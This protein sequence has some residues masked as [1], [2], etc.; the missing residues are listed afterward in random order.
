MKVL[1]AAVVVALLAGPAYGQEGHVQRYGEEAKPETQVQINANKAAE[2]A[3]RDSLSNIPDAGPV[4]PWGNARG[5]GAPKEAAKTAAKPVAKTA[6]K[7]TAPAKPK[8]ATT[9]GTTTN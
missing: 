4:D 2:K 9:A 1:R 6:A 7:T 3:Y 5:T 8:T